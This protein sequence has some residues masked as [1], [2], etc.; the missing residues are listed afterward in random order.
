MR[1]GDVERQTAIGESLASRA[2]RLAPRRVALSVGSSTGPALWMRTLERAP[3][4]C[5]R[6][7]VH[8]LCAEL[9]CVARQL[10]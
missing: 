9:Q 6:A 7:V 8:V 5:A 1:I 10:L 4:A 2:G 3:I